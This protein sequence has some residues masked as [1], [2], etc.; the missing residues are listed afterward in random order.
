MLAEGR[1]LNRRLG[2]P[3]APGSLCPGAEAAR[4][5]RSRPM[6]KL[7]SL[8]EPRL[9]AQRGCY[10]RAS[11]PGAAV[12]MLPMPPAPCRPAASR[13]LSRC[14][15]LPLAPLFWSSLWHFYFFA[16]PPS[17]LLFV[18]FFCCAC[19]TRSLGA[20]VCHGAACPPAPW[21]RTRCRVGCRAARAALAARHRASCSAGQQSSA[22]HPASRLG[23]LWNRL[24]ERNSL[25]L[26]PGPTCSRVS[27][28]RSQTEA[29][30]WGPFL[31]CPTAG[32]RGGNA[33]S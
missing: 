6:R 31:P 32:R 19:S 10:C 15:A 1:G 25:P 4:Q 33:I 5:S 16:S 20:E 14:R 18:F 8:P 9:L 30:L 23:P 17:L 13:A 2:R 24:T 28:R 7:L 22:S 12:R 26:P 21:G 29:V 11:Q 27:A 3:G